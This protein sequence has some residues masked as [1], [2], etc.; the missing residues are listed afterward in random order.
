[1]RS[2]I[3][4]VMPLL[5][6]FAQ[7]PTAVLSNGRLEL[8]IATRGGS[9]N[10][11]VLTGDSTQ[12][13]PFGD[14]ARMGGRVH[15]HF[16][17][18]DGFGPSSPEERAA[19]LGGHGEAHSLPWEPAPAESRANVR[20]LRFV[21][22]LPIVQETFTRTLSM[23]EGENV[24]YVD[25]EL[26]SWLGFDR[27]VNWGEHPTVASPFLE[28]EAVVVDVSGRRSKTRAHEAARQ[29]PRTLASFQDF[30]WPIAP[31]DGGGTR[32]IRSAPANADSRDHVTTLIDPARRHG[33]VTALH[34]GK[35][36]LLGYLFRREEYPWV[37]DWQLYPAD[38]RMYRGLEFATQPFDVPRREA[39]Q[40][41]SMFGAPTYRWLPAR[42]R[43]GSRFLMFWTRTPEG[44][45]R[46]DDVRLEGGRLIVE[47]RAAGRRITLAA[48]LG[49]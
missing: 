44:M 42:S 31:L 41:N 11:L 47:D 14:P 21:V 36:Y 20:A 12:L 30:E 1:M 8:T 28:P 7:Q 17:C 46:V 9:M 29:F 2:A 23:A 40:L 43:I 45:T 39:V 35:R 48:S 24:V 38:G 25:S 26:E 5:P 19:G 15:G 34:T 4:F 22:K 3:L 32:D 49:L 6:L 16:V 18:V 33:W 37:Q 13:S 27:P 10:R